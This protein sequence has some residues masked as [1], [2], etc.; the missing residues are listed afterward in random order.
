MY[1]RVLRFKGDPAKSDEAI[2]QWTEQIL[3]LIKKQKGFVG[4]SLMANRKTGDGLSVTYWETEQAMKDARA[5]VRPQADKIIGTTGRRIAEENECEVAVQE[6]F[7]PPKSGTWSR[8]TTIE[9][10]PAKI[11]DGIADYKAR[12]VPAIQRLS[13]ARAA[14]LLVDRNA[15]KSFSG[16]IWDSEKDLQTS[17][18]A[19]AGMRQDFAKKAGSKGPTVEVFEIVYTE[20]PAA[21]VTR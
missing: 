6:R 3:P 7:K 9:G 5:Q 20:I 16:T 4:V 19:V 12:V 14:V 10:D 18:A 8:V 21:V 13:G 15:G 11:D 17:E 1:G 2:K